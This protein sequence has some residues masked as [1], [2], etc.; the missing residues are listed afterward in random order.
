MYIIRICIANKFI[1]KLFV[2]RDRKCILIV[3]CSFVMSIYYW[4][5]FLLLTSRTCRF[6]FKLNFQVYG[7]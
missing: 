2:L 4:R 3:H 7:Q 6:N 1:E 5:K